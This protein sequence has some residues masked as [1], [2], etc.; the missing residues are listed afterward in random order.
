MSSKF[1]ESDLKLEKLFYIRATEV[2][3]IIADHTLHRVGV[4]MHEA[5]LHPYAITCSFRLDL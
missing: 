5:F 2:T 3:A 4:T 1:L